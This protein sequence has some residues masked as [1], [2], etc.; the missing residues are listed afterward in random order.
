MFIKQDPCQVPNKQMSKHISP[1]SSLIRP[2]LVLSQ[3]NYLLLERD[4]REVDPGRALESEDPT[5]DV[6]LLCAIVLFQARVSLPKSA[7]CCVYIYMHTHKRLPSSA[8]Q[9][10]CMLTHVMAMLAWTEPFYHTA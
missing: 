6:S 1:Q 4:L 2:C 5:C 8:N 9:L 3:G 10:V 7:C